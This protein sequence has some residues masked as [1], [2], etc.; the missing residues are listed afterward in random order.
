M[1]SLKRL[2][3]I[4]PTHESCSLRSCSTTT[5]IPTGT[6]HEMQ[7]NYRIHWISYSQ[8]SI[9]TVYKNDL[10]W[11][12]KGHYM[13]LSSL[14]CCQSTVFTWHFAPVYLCENSVEVKTP[15]TR[16]IEKTT[17][18]LML[19]CLWVGQ[20]PCTAERTVEKSADYHTRSG[21]EFYH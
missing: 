6:K 7:L 18:F 5:N 9:F 8:S 16:K 1:T 21:Y 12:R 15:T 20:W 3:C 10:D 17:I 19:V 4:L 14:C 2:F 13:F 11:N